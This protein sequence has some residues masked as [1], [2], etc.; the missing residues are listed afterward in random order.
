MNI[1]ETIRRLRREKNLT[2]ERFAEYLNVSPQAVSRWETDAAYPDITTIPV[3]ASFFGV[4]ADTLLGIDVSRGEE[5]IQ[6]YLREIQ[7]CASVGDKAG[8]ASAARRAFA[9]FP[10][11]PRVMFRYAVML[12]ASPWQQP[13][14]DQLVSDEAVAKVNAA[15]IALC[16]RILDDCGD[17]ELR[18]EVL[19]YLAM[20]YGFAGDMDSAVKTAKRLPDFNHTRNAALRDL[21]DTDSDE[22]VRLHQENIASLQELLWFEMRAIMFTQKDLD[23]K[24]S[25]LKKS[26]AI[27]ELL[28][29]D[30]DYGFGHF[31]QTQQHTLLADVCLKKGGADA[32]LENLERAA[33]HAAAADRADAGGTYTHTSVLFNKITRSADERNRGYEGSDKNLLLHK[34]GDAKYGALRETARFRAITASLTEDAG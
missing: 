23:A 27:G 7:L 12:S 5:R 6:A 8:Q 20:M 25:I 22:H 11:D 19:D 16:N 28:H 13:D 3:L 10:G 18:Y 33:E 2:Q 17:G 26:L 34:L 15:V 29:E 30:G 14:G 21:C 31:D 24:I 9:E 4:T 1:G 32:A